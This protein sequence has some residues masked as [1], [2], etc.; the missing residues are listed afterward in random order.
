MTYSRARSLAVAVAATCAWH[1]AP[2]VAQ[3]PEFNHS[4]VDYADPNVSVVSIPPNSSDAKSV[5]LKLLPCT[6]HAMVYG[7]RSVSAHSTCA[8]CT[9]GHA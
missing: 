9:R 1:A 8:A 2:T 6:M 3:C 5:N 7:G 4:G